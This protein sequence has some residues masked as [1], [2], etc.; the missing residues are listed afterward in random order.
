MS[1]D[2]HLP[3]GWSEAVRDTRRSISDAARY[4]VSDQDQPEAEALLAKIQE[5]LDR[6]RKRMEQSKT[7]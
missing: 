7:P 6:L 4:I 2:Y 1:E 5:S 3:P